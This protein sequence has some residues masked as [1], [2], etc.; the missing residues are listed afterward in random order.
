MVADPGTDYLLNLAS[1]SD[2]DFASNKADRKSLTGAVV[3][4]NGMILSWKCKKQGSVLLSTM[5][6][7]FVAASDAARKLLGARELLQELG[8]VIVS[9]M[10]M[11]IDNQAAIKNLEASHHLLKQSTS[12]LG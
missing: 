6:A 1:F 5:E 9:P 7:E 4:L 8:L 2:A 3:V 11:M 12:T 10:P